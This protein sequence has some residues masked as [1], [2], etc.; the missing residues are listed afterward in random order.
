MFVW[1]VG[2]RST[3]GL[4]LTLAVC[5]VSTV[6]TQYLVY[7]GL[8]QCVRSHLRCLFAICTLNLR[9]RYTNPDFFFVHSWL[10]SILFSGCIAIGT[11]GRQLATVRR[12]AR[13]GL[14]GWYRLNHPSSAAGMK[15]GCIY[16]LRRGGPRRQGSDAVLSGA[17]GR[18]RRHLARSGCPRG[19]AEE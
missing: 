2:D 17:G 14:Q 15:R 3:Y 1:W 5:F 13:E 16:D 12:R 8:Y 7:L 11:L 6:V 4:L 19:N 10:P 18:T 9:P